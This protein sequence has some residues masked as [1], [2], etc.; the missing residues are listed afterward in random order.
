MSRQVLQVKGYNPEQ[1]KSLFN[2]DEKY[3]LGIKLYAIYQVSRGQASRRLEDLYNTSFKQICNWVHRFEEEGIEGLK[4]KPKSGK[5]SLMSIE[6]KAELKK[7]LETKKPFDYGYNKSTWNGPILIDFIKNTYSISYKKAQIYN[8]LK[9]LG[10]TYQKGRARY[11][12]A[13]E[14]KRDEFKNTYKK[15]SGRT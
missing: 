12:E 7:I 11:P 3:Q 15:T 9:A 6:Q 1:I 4:R 13:D 5:P 2:Q 14:Q 8:I 10:F